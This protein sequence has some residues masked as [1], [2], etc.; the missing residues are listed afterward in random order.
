[1]VI[2]HALFDDIVADLIDDNFGR[3]QDLIL[4]FQIPVCTWKN[5]LEIY[6]HFGH[7]PTNSSPALVRTFFA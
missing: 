4:L 7:A 1:M 2:I 3:L 5:S 6:G